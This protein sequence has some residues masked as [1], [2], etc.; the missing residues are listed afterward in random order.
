MT[1]FDKGALA[2]LAK[3]ARVPLDEAHNK[4]ILADMQGILGH[5][6]ELQEV[7]IDAVAPVTG[8]TAQENVLREDT[9]R[10]L[11]DAEVLIDAF[12]EQEGRYLRV[13]KVL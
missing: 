6:E 12:P 10:E 8:G 13:P 9:P 1:S 3:L 7:S 11:G 2:H 4:K 5:F